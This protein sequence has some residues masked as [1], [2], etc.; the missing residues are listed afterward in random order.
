MLT[1]ASHLEAATTKACARYAE[2]RLSGDD[3]E[4]H[5][6]TVRKAT[7][8]I[9]INSQ[10]AADLVQSFKQVAVDQVSEGY[11]E[12][13]LGKYIAEILLSLHPQFKNTRSR[14]KVDCQEDLI[15]RGYPGALSQCLTNLILNSLIHAYA[16]G[17][18]GFIAIKATVDDHEM[19]TLTYTD[20]GKGIPPEIQDKVFDPFF[21]T[22]RGSG[23][24]GLGLHIVYN[25]VRDTLGGDVRLESTP[26]SGTTF[27][28]RF[29][30]RLP[31][32][33]SSS[34]QLL[35]PLYVRCAAET[36]ESGASPLRPGADRRP[37]PTAL[38]D[39]HCG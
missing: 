37:D 3:L 1:A 28:L 23:G 20:D 11:R 17:Q 35:E 25:I 4:E 6:A 29:P 21:T 38:E 33:C 7:Q 19:V 14:I 10:R 18:S 24:S 30:Q 5:F 12:F 27:V 26:G 15:I 8:H 22:K 13:E 36:S 32:P 9:I 34:Q 31:P 16:P 39:P 2:G